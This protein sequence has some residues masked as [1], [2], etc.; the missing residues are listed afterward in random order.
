MDA[1][2]KVLVRL[3]EATGGRDTQAVDFKELVK[4][5]GFLGNYEDV[6]Q[7][8]STQGWIAETPKENYVTITH[9]GVKEAQESVSGTSES[10]GAPEIKRAAH[11][12]IN[13]TKEFLTALEEFQTDASKENFGRVE[14]K[15][16]ELKAAID[17]LRQSIQ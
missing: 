16:D 9:W 6:F 1:Y 7:K 14:K 3:Y 2:H 17:K 8:L 13:E 12:L 10:S 4:A 5:E 15:F 11:F